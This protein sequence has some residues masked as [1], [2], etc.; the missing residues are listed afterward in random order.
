MKIRYRYYAQ[1]LILVDLSI[2]F[3]FFGHSSAHPPERFWRKN[4]E[5]FPLS[6]PDLLQPA[7]RAPKKNSKNLNFRDRNVW[8]EIN[9]CW[10][11][12]TCVFLLFAV[13]LHVGVI[14]M[15]C[16]HPCLSTHGMVWHLPARDRPKRCFSFFFREGAWVVAT[17]DGVWHRDSHYWRK[18]IWGVHRILILMR[19]LL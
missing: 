10:N 19:D 2:V 7:P 1:I 14:Y 16:Q 5:R 4:Q 18:F 8:K 11:S 17:P 15:M 3:C 6:L 9:G 13:L 12:S